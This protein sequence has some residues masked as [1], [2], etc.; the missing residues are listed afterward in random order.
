M[1]A[2]SDRVAA[3]KWGGERE[4]DATAEN[5]C[6]RAG[7]GMGVRATAEDQAAW[8]GGWDNEAKKRKKEEEKRN[9]KGKEGKGKGE[10]GKRKG[11]AGA[12]PTFSLGLGFGF[13]FGFGFVFGVTCRGSA[14]AAGGEDGGEE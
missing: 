7:A 10:R 6:A 2:F 4:K 8:V 11:H 14:E 9:E 3:M 13:G 12:V 1:G 5:R